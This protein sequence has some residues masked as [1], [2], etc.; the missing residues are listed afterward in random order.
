MIPV[1]YSLRII[2]YNSLGASPKSNASVVSCLYCNT[3]SN[4]NFN[5]T[6]GNDAL[7][8]TAQTAAQEPPYVIIFSVVGSVLVVIIITV[9]AVLLL[10]KY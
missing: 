6:I 5:L 3:I 7:N 4:Q 8:E 2:V 1:N 9:V 10:T